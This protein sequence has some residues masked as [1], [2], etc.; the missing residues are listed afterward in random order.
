MTDMKRCSKGDD[1]VHEMGCMQP[2]TKKYFHLSSKTKDGFKHQCK[3]CRKK[4]YETNKKGILCQ[5]KE[6]Y[7]LNKDIILD[8]NRQYYK[9]NKDKVKKQKKKNREENKTRTLERLRQWRIK[10]KDYMPKY[11]AKNKARLFARYSKNKNRIKLYYREYRNR[12]RE[13]YREYHR[14]YSSNRRARINDLPNTFTLEQWE[15]CLKYF[16]YKC[17]I[18][19]ASK[20]EIGLEIDHW[21]PIN[22]ENCTGT[23]A[24]NI[25]PLC[26]NREG[27]EHHIGCNPS[28]SD[29]DP[30]EYLKQRYGQ[31]Q[32]DKIYQ[33]VMDYFEWV[34]SQIRK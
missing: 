26:G 31:I 7:E 16:G 32:A 15:L 4:Y 22:S 12:N 17:A 27:L 18:C 6:F 29:K 2:A 14:L 24:T 20:D 3:M 13:W 10:N 11:R 21:I 34:S 33:R 1:C 28:K 19:G 30:Y 9:N 8:R 5:K 25:V 23:I